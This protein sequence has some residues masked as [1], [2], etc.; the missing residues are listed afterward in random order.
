MTTP[1]LHSAT[2]R[3]LPSLLKTDDRTPIAPDRTLNQWRNGRW[4]SFSTE[5][6]QRAVEE[7][8]LGLETFGLKRGDRIA[9]I[10]HSDVGF[11]IADLGTLLAGFV[12]VPIDLTQTIENILLI[13]QEVE[14]PL[15]VVSNLDLLD[16]IRPYL[17]EVPTL[18]AVIVA[19]VAEKWGG[20]RV[21]E[22]G[23][24]GEGGASLPTPSP[25]A[26]LQIP[27]L[28]CEAQVQQPCPPVPMPQSLRVC[29]LAEVR[30]W[31]RQRWSAQAV[32]ALEDAITPA[33]L[34]TVIYIASETKRPKG[35]MLSHGAIAANALAAFASYPHLQHGPDEVALLFLPLTHIFARVFLYGHLA[36]GHSIYFSDPNHL[37]KH[38]RRVRPT[39]VITVP[40]FLEKVHERILDHAHHL[41]RFDRRVLLWAIQLTARF[42]PNQ[43]PQ[44]LYRLQM[45]LAERLV[46]PKWRAVFGGRLK[47]CICGGAALSGDLV[48]F[49]SAAGVPV[50]QG[51]GLTETSGVLTYTR[52]GH[53]RPGTVGPPIPGVEVA[54][55]PDQEILVRAP[56][57]MQGYYR[58]PKASNAALTADGWLHTGDLGHLDAD[59]FLTVT[60]VK[61]A[62]FKLC[63]GKYVSP[64]PL[65]E[66]LSASPL[67]AQAVTVGANRKFCAMVIVPELEPLRRQAQAWDLDTASPDWWHHPRIT[68]L[69][70]SLIDSANCHLPYWATV[71]KFALVERSE[72]L[73][74]AV[75][76]LYGDG[77]GRGDRE[78][79]EGGGES[80]PVY[81]RS[82]VGG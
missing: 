36:W 34:A 72:E 33:D 3:T 38:L 67:V 54:I 61:K 68:A 12:N 31:G 8:A 24:E 62:L 57:L 69:Y 80:C 82:L 48:K 79:G 16:Q 64:R 15:L 13:L 45:Q 5:A 44:G 29:S 51:Y 11:A 7:L 55:A 47:A 81:A 40:R 50:Y 76:R 26:C 71:R 43:P 41:S 46:F 27:H 78:D 73:A 21:M 53:N 4:Q 2:H 56:F 70:Q 23:D 66:E 65:E 52:E 22:W 30:R 49:F 6:L 39:F 10:M 17:W 75:E 28:L 14:A 19:E 42:D 74:A 9:L 20:G 77:G 63:T 1:L 18:K 35:V 60:G 32:Q 37:V 59:G 25:D 58:D